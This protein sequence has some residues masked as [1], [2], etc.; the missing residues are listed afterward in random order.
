MD[1]EDNDFKPEDDDLMEL[2]EVPKPTNQAAQLPKKTTQRAKKEPKEATPISLEDEESFSTKEKTVTPKKAVSTPKKA[3]STPKKAVSTPKKAA[4]QKTTP[5][6]TSGRTAEQVLETIPDAELP[7]AE[8]TDVKFNYHAAQSKKADGVQPS[9]ESVEIGEAQPNC[10][11]GLTIVFTGV[12]PK[13]DRDAS[14]NLAKRYGA[15]VTK[16][17]LGKTSLVVI[18]TDA[19]PSKIKKIKQ[20]GIKAIDE[21]G[22]IQLLRSM[23]AEGGDGDAALKAKEKREAEERRIIEETEAFEAQERARE[24]AE[25]K[26]EKEETLLASKSNPNRPPPEAKRAIPNSEKLW[27]VR[28]A[29]TELTQLCGNKGQINKLKEWL[30]NWSDNARNGFKGGDPGCY[31]AALISGPPGIGKTSAAHL[32]AKQLGFDILEKNA[33]D[34]RSKSL[35][36]SSIKSVLSNTSV[37]G[38]FNK[39]AQSTNSKKFCL[40]MDEVDGMSSGDRG[41]AG[42]LSAFCKITNMPM[43]L[44]CNDKLLPKMR[45]FDRVTYDLAFRR[46]SETEV[47]ARLMTIALREKIKLDPTVIGQLV[48]ATHND[49]RQMINILL[50][51]STLQKT[52]GRE[53]SAQISKSWQ[54]QTVLKP[55]DIAGKLLSSHMH[56]GHTLA[57]LN[58]QI[59]LYFNDIDFTPLMIQENYINTR[60]LGVTSSL[61]HLKRVAQA[62]DDILQLDRINNLI[63]SLE[64]QWSL[65]PFHAV[66]SSV[67]PSL[68]VAGNMSGRMAFSSWL[69][70]NSKT[71][72]YQRLLQ[73]LQ[74]HARLRTSADKTELRLQYL[75]LMVKRLTD[76]LLK[77][78]EDGIDEV[79]AM[80]DHYYLTREDWEYLID[81]GVGPGNGEA[82]LKKLAT[83]TKSAFTRRY[84]AAS[85]P[86]AIY[87]TGNSVGA[88][89]GGSGA[90]K[91]D[92]EDVIVDD[93]NEKEEEDE[94]K[95]DG[96]IDVK[97][98][99]LIKEV[100]PKKPSA[101]K[102]K[103]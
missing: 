49:I 66:M 41:G 10:L 28:H 4:S 65:L 9:G 60:P 80:L 97:K 79:M 36:N 20:F 52:I 34:V 58:A 17:I 26:R 82:L 3:V 21:D 14:E 88:N 13:L 76:P 2:D 101:K 37:V 93:T 99:K 95:D 83:K 15:R 78:G 18:G 86:V 43:I 67:R 51:V 96:K 12:L 19:G 100:K 54:K 63:R 11:S 75:P 8:E 70:Q 81:F 56:S 24:A 89:R 94:E 48:E 91:A 102:R 62:A 27:T 38:F 29:P 73:E 39:G 64:Q 72:K 32:V 74:Y 68:A 55:F 61:D 77:L 22:F 46:P 6:A 71:M 57:D 59:D 16:S 92:Y 31:R 85:H 87:K 47:K 33:S 42:A 84:N 23:P 69:G 44:I 1:S 98:D 30:S 25:R 53:E 35:L 40:I 90:S 103:K 7:E 50:T 5:P 45:T